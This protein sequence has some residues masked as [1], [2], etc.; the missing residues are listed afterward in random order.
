[1]NFF[2]K[3]IH[4]ET[5]K[6]TNSLLDQN[7]PTM[8]YS[9]P[10]AILRDLLGVFIGPSNVV[11][12]SVLFTLGCL[13]SVIP[14]LIFKVNSRTRIDNTG[15]ESKITSIRPAYRRPHSPFHYEL[16]IDADVIDY[17]GLNF[18]DTKIM[19]NA[20][21]FI[22]NRRMNQLPQ[23]ET[24]PV[25]ASTRSCFLNFSY[26]EVRSPLGNI[27]ID[28]NDCYRKAQFSRQTKGSKLYLF[29]DHR[30]CNLKING[31][32][33]AIWADSEIT[34]T[35]FNIAAAGAHDIIRGAFDSIVAIPSAFLSYD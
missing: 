4:N 26:R 18:N 21:E 30:G 3:L 15:T 25:E 28:P 11:K 20:V 8:A 19:A 13:Q 2:E 35:G 12:G 10:E 5:T 17:D 23:F 9:E 32:K 24:M 14:T 22:I 7:A 34:V 27:L 33:G 16:S 1:M 29:Y 31:R 6:T